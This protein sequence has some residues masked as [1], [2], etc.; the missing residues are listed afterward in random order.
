M[1]KGASSL[2]FGSLNGSVKPTEGNNIPQI[3]M[4]NGAFSEL[5]KS[6]DDK[7]ENKTSKLNFSPTLTKPAG[8]EKQEKDKNN[9]T[10][11]SSFKKYQNLS[12][13]KA[14]PQASTFNF[15]NPSESKEDSK[16]P[17]SKLTNNIDKF[18]PDSKKDSKFDFAFISRQDSLSSFNYPIIDL[19]S[20]KTTS[21]DKRPE[22][23]LELPTQPPT[24]HPFTIT[25]NSSFVF[26]SSSSFSS[27]CD[28]YEFNFGTGVNFIA[29]TRSPF[30][31][32]CFS[33]TPKDDDDIEDDFE[34]MT[35]AFVESNETGE[36]NEE[37]LIECNTKVY[38][39]KFTI[40]TELKEGETKPEENEFLKVE[41]HN[42][43][44]YV[45]RKKFVV[46]GEGPLHLNKG[47]GY[48]RIVV[49][50]NKV[51]TIIVNSRVFERMNPSLKDNKLRILLQNIED[52][53]EGVS[54]YL[55]K[56]DEYETAVKVTEEIKKAIQEISKK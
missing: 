23:K 2:S 55:L 22:I 9:S 50:R 42:D 33:Y 46:K 11:D 26:P 47:N 44:D 17:S 24:S 14:A 54:V 27:L 18:S 51:G 7:E 8:D 45:C 36:E 30:G 37:N 43:K 52:K 1:D 21:S 48:Y 40:D 41:R 16:A 35:P 13:N 39:F 6:I 28:T 20:A 38:Q 10:T 5:I 15:G 3:K 34:N 32:N 29:S 25:P 53:E 31:A 12:F 49:R 56:F 4:P 19:P